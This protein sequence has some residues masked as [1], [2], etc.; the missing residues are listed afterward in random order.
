[1]EKPW[2]NH[3]KP[4]IVWKNHEKPYTV[5]TLGMF[6]DKYYCTQTCF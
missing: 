1:M 3:G 6:L 2:K 5:Y 4:G